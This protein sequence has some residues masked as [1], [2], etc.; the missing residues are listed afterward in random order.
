MLGNAVC[1]VWTLYCGSRRD[2]GMHPHMTNVP[3]SF[4]DI[5]LDLSKALGSSFTP[6]SRVSLL[7]SHHALDHQP[8]PRAEGSTSIGVQVSLTFGSHV[9]TDGYLGL[10][11]LRPYSKTDI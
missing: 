11:I 1:G 8:G 5:A 6:V 7:I 10:F 2:T 9:I 3:G 4:P